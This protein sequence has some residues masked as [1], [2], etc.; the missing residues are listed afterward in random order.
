MDVLY[1]TDKTYKIQKSVDT[2][3]VKQGG[4]KIA[5]V[6]L[7]HLKSVVLF[8]YV[9]LSTQVLHLLMSSGVNIFY[10]DNK[11]EVIGIVL[12]NQS[13]NVLLRISQYRLWENQEFRVE[14][15]KKI[16][17]AKIKNQ[18]SFINKH[19]NDKGIDQLKIKQAEKFLLEQLKLMKRGNSIQSVMGYEGICAKVYFEVFGEFLQRF[20]FHK[21]ERRPAKNIVN[22]LLNYTYAFLRNEMILRLA[23]YGFDIELGF[24]HGVRYGRD[25]LALDLMEVF[26]PVFADEFVLKLLK[27]GYLTE[28]SFEIVDEACVL[29]AEGVGIFC[30]Q[31]ELY[32]TKLDLG[33]SWF[34]LFDREIK[35]FRASVFSSKPYSPFVFKEREK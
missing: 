14:F 3:V 1:V 12:S 23:A 25:S 30:T 27:G 10:F 4:R 13:N 18:V 24:I 34:R 33:T 11:G 32:L 29:T 31:Y 2:L 17:G 22:A 7:V 35:R 28:Q 6:P 8:G 20:E 26:R 9:Q 16:G 15:S 5:S 19:L 21:R